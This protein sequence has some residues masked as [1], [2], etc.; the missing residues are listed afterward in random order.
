MKKI[1]LTLT[2]LAGFAL[3][4]CSDDDPVSCKQ[5]Q[6]EVTPTLT[7]DCSQD[8]TKSLEIKL[9]CPQFDWTIAA[10]PWI[11]PSQTSGKGTATIHVTVKAHAFPRNGSITVTARNPQGATDI[12][13]CK[14]EQTEGGAGL[15]ITVKVEDNTF[16]RG[17]VVAVSL[18]SAAAALFNGL[19]QSC[20]YNAGL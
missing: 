10:D 9:N 19:R 18:R 15:A 16:S 5:P 8:Q 3:V 6:L 12:A 11:E 7:F 4:S 20:R 14:V 2:L 13:R 17:N 1:L